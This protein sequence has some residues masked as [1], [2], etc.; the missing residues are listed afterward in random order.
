[1]IPPF[2]FLKLITYF[3]VCVSFVSRNKREKKR[4]KREYRSSVHTYAKDINILCGYD[5]M[6]RSVLAVFFLNVHENYNI[7]L[8]SDA[9]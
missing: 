7:L 5:K 2:F 9:R 1:M 3:F 4:K 8:Q 6:Q